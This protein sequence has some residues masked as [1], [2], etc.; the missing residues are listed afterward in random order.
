[1]IKYTKTHSFKTSDIQKETL[2]KMKFYNVNVSQFIRD[3]IKEKLER[4]KSEFIPRKIKEIEY[5]PFSNGTI[6]LTI[7]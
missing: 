6:I 5:C 1:M 7:N 3:A 2:N 4:D